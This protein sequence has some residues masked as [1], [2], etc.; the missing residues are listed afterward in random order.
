M[1]S[2]KFAVFYASAKEINKCYDKRDI[3]LYYSKI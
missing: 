2:G 1:K 3:S